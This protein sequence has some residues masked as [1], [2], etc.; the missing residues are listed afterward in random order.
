VVPRTDLGVS[1]LVELLGH[2][3][4]ALLFV[5]IDHVG[6]LVDPTSGGQKPALRVGGGAREK[7]ERP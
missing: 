7:S 2:D 4:E 3:R 1:P 6:K 5:G